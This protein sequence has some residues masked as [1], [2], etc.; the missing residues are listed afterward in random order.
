MMYLLLKHT[1]QERSQ[2]SIMVQKYNSEIKEVWIQISAPA[3]IPLAREGLVL[4]P[5]LAQKALSCVPH[6]G[7]LLRALMD[8]GPRNPVQADM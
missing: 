2:H 4:S 5:A 8:E 7:Y 1:N 3:F 6:P